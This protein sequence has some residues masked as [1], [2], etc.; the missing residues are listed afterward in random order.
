V[1]ARIEGRVKEILHGR[2]VA[3]VAIPRA[4]GSV[5]SVIVWAS[6]EDGLLTLNSAVGRAWPANLRRAGRATVTM[7]ADGN[8]N[9]WISIE[10][11]LEEAT[12][13]GAREH[14]DAL[15]I[16]YGQREFRLRS[17]T[18]QRVKFTLRPE[19]IYYLKQD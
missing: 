15:A 19:R 11:R 13:T 1:S 5:H 7:M 9:E 4:D 3:H 14:I 8:S 17:A 12:T 6:E 10:G 2:D 16:K 18:E